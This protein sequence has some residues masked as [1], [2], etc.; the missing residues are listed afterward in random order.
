MNQNW[1]VHMGLVNDL[2]EPRARLVQVNHERRSWPDG[3]N[4]LPGSSGTGAADHGAER[5][6]L[7]HRRKESGVLEHTG[8]GSKGLI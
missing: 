7:Q 1:H 4:L 8:Y 5:H 3:G 2:H 6:V